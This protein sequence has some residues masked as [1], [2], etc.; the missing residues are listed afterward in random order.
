MVCK[1]IFLEGNTISEL[2][3]NFGD[4]T[5]EALYLNRNPLKD[6]LRYFKDWSDNI[7]L[8]LNNTPLSKNNGSCVGDYRKEIDLEW[9]L[10][11]NKDLGGA[12]DCYDSGLF[13]FKVDL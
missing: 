5:C 12:K 3:K 4:L 8:Y 13:D 11:N 9:E 1:K 6:G 2:P 10:W 7:G